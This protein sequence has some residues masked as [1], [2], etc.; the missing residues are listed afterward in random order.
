MD[1]KAINLNVQQRLRALEAQMQVLVPFCIALIETHPDR[2]RL[3][4]RFAFHAETLKA[5][6]LN[7]AIADDFLT[8]LDRLRQVLDA[9]FDLPNPSTRS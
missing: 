8:E 5:R 6:A 2:D 3:R 7:S 1:Q 4:Q 9:T